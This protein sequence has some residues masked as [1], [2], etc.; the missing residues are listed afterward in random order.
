MIIEALT[1]NRNRTASEL[2]TS[3]AKNGGTLG[4]TNSVSFMFD[5]VGEIVYPAKKASADDMLEAVIEA[6]GDNVESDDE[7]HVITTNV[8]DFGAVRNALESKYGEPESAKLAWV[9]KNQTEVTGDAA[10]SLAKLL[11]ILEDNDDVQ[12]VFGNYELPDA[13]MAKL[14]S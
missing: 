1:D 13:E 4:E 9:P 2:R 5:R 6:G 11:D 3:L 14:A 10:Q 12:H 8:E 7:E